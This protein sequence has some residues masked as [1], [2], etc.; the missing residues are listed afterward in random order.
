MSAYRGMA[1]EESVFSLIYWGRA[2]KL[3]FSSRKR[4]NC[5]T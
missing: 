4:G 3:G 1:F 5:S 2:H